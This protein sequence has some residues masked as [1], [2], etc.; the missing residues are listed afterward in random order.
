LNVSGVSESYPTLLSPV[1]VKDLVA[2]QVQQDMFDSKILPK[3]EVCLF[4]SCDMC[5]KAE[6]EPLHRVVSDA[7][8]ITLIKVKQLTQDD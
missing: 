6:S 3:E 8:G 4:S 7:M 5:P 2:L 1:L